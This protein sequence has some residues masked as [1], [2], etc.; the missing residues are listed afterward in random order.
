MV[1]TTILHQIDEDIHNILYSLHLID[2]MRRL[3]RKQ[4]TLILL[5]LIFAGTSSTNAQLFNPKEIILT[6]SDCNKFELFWGNDSLESVILQE[7]LRR[8]YS[9]VRI[10]YKNKKTAPTTIHVPVEF[11]DEL[12]RKIK[13]NESGPVLLRSKTGKFFFIKDKANIPL[14]GN[15]MIWKG[16]GVQIKGYDSSSFILV[17]DINRIYQVSRKSLEGKNYNP[18]DPTDYS[19]FLMPTGRARKLFGFGISDFMV[20]YPGVNVSLP[21]N[22]TLNGGY[23]P[24]N[25]LGYRDKKK[26][27]FAPKISLINHKN[28]AFAIGS[29]NIMYNPDFKDL[30][31]IP[32]YTYGVQT[33]SYKRIALTTGVLFQDLAREHITLKEKVPANNQHFFW[34]LELD[35]NNISK[36]MIEGVVL[37]DYSNI[38]IIG[39]R[40]YAE[41]ASFQLGLVFYERD[42]KLKLLEIPFFGLHYYFF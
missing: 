39:I 37:H 34:G 11:Y 32:R 5:I 4:N 19:L 16:Y 40:S 2:S 41:R 7:P 8:D 38:G 22:I 9:I 30:E 10:F 21:L 24:N 42:N 36:V 28:Y 35:I 18:D 1:F 3:I 20:I 26:Y 15:R 14:S 6:K 27:W 13:K 12:K 25:F 17:D 23:I 33:L 29:F 31:N